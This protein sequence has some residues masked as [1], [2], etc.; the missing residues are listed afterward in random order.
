MSCIYN[1]SVTLTP[2]CMHGHLFMHF[3]GDNSC[4]DCK[5]Y[6]KQSHIVQQLSLQ[7]G[8]TALHFA[9]WQGHSNIIKIL[10]DHGAVID[11]TSYV[12]L[13]CGHLLTIIITLYATL[14]Y[15]QSPCYSCNKS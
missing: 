4:P 10:V 9:S 5:L 8:Y 13:L 11:M 15:S 3:W 14:Y 2:A 7:D 12:S 6:K 1:V